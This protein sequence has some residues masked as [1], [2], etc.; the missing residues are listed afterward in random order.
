VSYIATSATPVAL[1]SSTKAMT[2]MLAKILAQSGQLYLDAA[3][4]EIDPA[5]AWLESYWPQVT[6]RQLLTHTSGSRVSAESD[7]A[8]W[9]YCDIDLNESVRRIR[10]QG[11]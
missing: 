11:F 10:E 5:P 1:G 8:Q 7:F 4:F 6:L 3:P 2:T 9:R